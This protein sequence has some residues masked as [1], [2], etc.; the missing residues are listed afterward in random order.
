MGHVVSLGSVNVD[1]VRSVTGEEIAALR[2]RH[3]WFPERG[4][5][6]RVDTVPDA[7]DDAVDR[8]E[9][10]GKGAN[11]AVAAAR[12]D[13]EATLLGRVGTDE[14]RFGVREELVG[15]GV[16]VG[17]VE[18]VAEP[19]GTAYVF[20]DAA[21]DSWILVRPGAN[22]AVDEA[23]VRA[24]YEHVVAADCLL[25]Q[26]E[27]PVEPV[28]WLL[29]ALADEPSRPTVILDPAPVEGVASLLSRDAVDYLVPNE[30]E[31]AA[32]GDALD[33][34][35]GTVVRT[36]G[37]DAITVEGDGDHGGFTVTPPAVTPVDTTGAGDVLNGY[38]GARLAAGASLRAAIETAAVAA[39]L[40][41]RRDGARRGVPTLAEVEAF[42]RE[43][44]VR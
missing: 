12:A 10:G 39:A 31:A 36:R 29:D 6:V 9:H 24:R 35:E 20:V 33:A 15:A 8:I 40:S 37:G 26:N 19:T 18:T 21:G 27:I 11:Q 7:F 13:A 4:E 34:F 2:D 16:G 1:R 28:R 32:L 14:D 5:T 3:E 17:H 23:Y 43:S 38:L 25:L 44:K 41:T 30:R 22:G 42:E